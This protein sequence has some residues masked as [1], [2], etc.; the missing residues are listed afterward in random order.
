ML[1]CR[2]DGA[3][4]DTEKLR[5]NLISK[6]LM[7]LDEIQAMSP[8]QLV[9][10]IFMPGI[11]TAANSDEDAGR[12]IGLDLVRHEVAKHGGRLRLQSSPGQFTEF[13]IRFEG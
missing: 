9:Q 3:G 2:D 5:T 1:R 12:G 6:G 7:P 4:I 10:T 8:Q 11:S 13:S